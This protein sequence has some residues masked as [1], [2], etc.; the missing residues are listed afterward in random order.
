MD[1]ELYNGIISMVNC[2]CLT[3]VLYNVRE[4]P[5]LREYTKIYAKVFRIRHTMSPTYFKWFGK[6]YELCLYTHM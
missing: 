2:L 3:T 5:A 6:I 1:C 4:C